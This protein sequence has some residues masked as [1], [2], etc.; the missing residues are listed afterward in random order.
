MKRAISFC[1]IIIM[2]MSMMVCFDVTVFAE[3]TVVS[4]KFTPT[5]QL[6]FI[7]ETD[8]TEITRIDKDTG[9]EITYMGYDVTEQFWRDGNIITLTYADD[10][11]VDYICKDGIFIASNG[12]SLDNYEI[13][14]DDTRIESTLRYYITY[15]GVSTSNAVRLYTADFEKFSFIPVEKLSVVENKDGYVSTRVNENGEEEE[16]FHYQL[17][18]FMVG[19]QIVLWLNSYAKITYT[20]DGTNFRGARGGQ[21]NMIGLKFADNQKKEP[22]SVGVNYVTLILFQKTVEVP[23][24]VVN[25]VPAAPELTSVVNRNNNVVLSWEDC[26]TASS[27]RVYRRAAGEKYW[28]YLAT[29]GLTSYTDT[30]VKN[31]VFYKY[32]VRGTNKL[33][34]GSF[35]SGLVIKHLKSAQLTSIK[36]T[37]NGIYFNWKPVAGATAYRIYRRIG[38]SKTWQYMGWVKSTA[39]E[40]KRVANNYDFTYTVMPVGNG[41]YGCYDNIGITTTRLVAPTV[42]VYNSYWGVRISW[43][44][45]KGADEYRI[46][47]RAAGGSWCYLGYV[48]GRDTSCTDESVQSG[49]YYTYTV[50]AVKNNAIS[51]YR[52]DT[53]VIMRVEAPSLNVDYGIFDD[54]VTVSWE[55]VDVAQGYYLYKKINDGEW[56]KIGTYKAKNSTFK[57]I[58]YNYDSSWY[59]CRYK[60]VAYSGKYSNETSS[61]VH[62]GPSC[63]CGMIY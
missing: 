43:N 61:H 31:N 54:Y 47:R 56:V 8:K 20:Y 30:T 22:W 6:Y 50:R 11:V 34:Y 12:N 48:S 5:E 3:N 23:V 13:I 44:S 33:G 9:E 60:V 55:P 62:K 21:I 59:S 18:D 29:T 19:D 63:Y 38:E 49:K 57:Y 42:G 41:Y 45:I 27:Y 1:L 10:S 40:D 4:I 39:Y 36:N 35:E 51:G 24:S 26:D 25:T 14:V 32:T 17:R 15:C 37:V 46:Y 58:D 52:T 2:V 16:Y 28:T 53:P 7:K